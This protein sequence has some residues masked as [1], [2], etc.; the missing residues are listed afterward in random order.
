MPA[1]PGRPH[2]AAGSFADPAGNECSAGRRGELA[3]AMSTGA[4]LPDLEGSRPGQHR[5]GTRRADVRFSPRR[6]STTERDQLANDHD[7]TFANVAS[8]KPS[9]DRC[10]R[11]QA[12]PTPQRV[13]VM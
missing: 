10:R 9:G 13:P 12:E 7:A 5:T 1:S 6:A 3:P 11:V 8:A 4:Y 2:H